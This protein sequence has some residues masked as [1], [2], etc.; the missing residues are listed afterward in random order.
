MGHRRICSNRTL[1]D[2]EEG[3]AISQRPKILLE[4]WGWPD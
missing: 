1:S 3:G 4:R 2:I